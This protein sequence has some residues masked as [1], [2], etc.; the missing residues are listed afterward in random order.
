MSTTTTKA[1]VVPGRPTWQQTMLRIADPAKSLP[2]Y[3]DVMGMTLIDTL[4]FP[5][6][7]FKLYF[8]TTL[9]EGETYKLTPGTK[10]AHDYMWSLEGTAMELT[11]NYGTEDPSFKGY[12]AGNQEKD[13]FGH[14][15]F[16]TDDVYAACEKLEQAG[17]AFKKKPDEGR[18]KGLAF[19][20]DPDGYWVE[21]L[22]RGE[23]GKIPN[24]FNF[25]Q[26][27]LRIKDPTKTI[28]FYEAMGMKVVRKKNYGSFSNYFLTTNCEGIIDHLDVENMSDEE[29]KKNMSMLFGPV[30]ELTHNHGTENDDDFKHYNGNEEGRQGFGHIGFLVDDVYEACDGIRTMGYG[31]KKEPDGG[32]MKGLAF[33]YDPDGYAIEIIKRGGIEFGDVKVESK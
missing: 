11:H 2:F 32:S 5:Q 10:E 30:L 19:A 31:F 26:T 16:N 27:M 21:I 9:P 14:V 20:Y 13:G 18:M 12:H 15:A 8:L 1:I 7:S 25:S 4:D 6:W 17:V 33:A 22:K 23:A 24:Y 3:Q 28:P 29:A